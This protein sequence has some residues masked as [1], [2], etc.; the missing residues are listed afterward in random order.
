MG[1]SEVMQA[2]SEVQIIVAAIVLKTY[3]LSW[4]EE[5]ESLVKRVKS[6]LHAICAC[7]RT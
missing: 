7:G 6:W 3:E 5:K 4:Q 2:M 1:W